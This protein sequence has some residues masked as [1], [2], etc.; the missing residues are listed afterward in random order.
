MLALTGCRL[1]SVSDARWSEFSPVV[2]DAVRRRGD[3][4]VDWS[5]FSPDDLW[6][7]Q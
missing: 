7:S 6:C 2:R 5:Q 3:K 4:P 1:A